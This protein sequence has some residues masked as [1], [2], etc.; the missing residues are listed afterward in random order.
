MRPGAGRLEV[1]GV[2]EPDRLGG[3]VDYSGHPARGLSAFAHGWAG[4]ERDALDRWRA[5]YGAV[6]GVRWTW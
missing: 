4:A 5:G 2:V 3:T 1:F 6:G